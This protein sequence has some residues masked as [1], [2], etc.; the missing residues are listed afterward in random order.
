MFLIE[1]KRIAMCDELF[2]DATVP[3]GPTPTFKQIYGNYCGPGNKGGEPIDAIDH[4]CKNHDMCYHYKGRHNC[5]CDSKF[6]NELE[7]LLT[8]K[9]TFKQR[10]VAQ[11]MKKYFTRALT[12]RSGDKCGCDHCKGNHE[13]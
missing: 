13:A 9:L 1:I 8:S 11:M 2:E 3:F 4:A 5:G 6:V 12:K 10:V 7:M